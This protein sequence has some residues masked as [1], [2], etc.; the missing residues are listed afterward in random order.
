VNPDWN[1]LVQSVGPAVHRIAWR[2]LGHAQDAEDTVQ[3]VFLEAQRLWPGSD[4]LDWGAVLRRVTVCRALDRLRQRRTQ[5]LRDESCVA[6]HRRGPE[7]II[8]SREVEVILRDAIGRL[9]PREAEIFCMRFFDERG[10][11]EIADLLG[12]TTSA[13][14]TAIHKARQKLEAVLRP[15]LTEK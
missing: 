12:I 2:I 11:A 5:T 13:V 4:V 1:D 6:E 7:E 8:V 15:V 3:D 14:G 9:P 10:Y